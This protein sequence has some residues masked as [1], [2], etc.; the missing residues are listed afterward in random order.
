MGGF[1][2]VTVKPTDTNLTLNDVTTN[3]ASIS[4]HG[5]LPK[6]SGDAK[7]F[8]NGLGAFSQPDIMG[9]PVWQVDCVAG[10]YKVYYKGAYTG[11]TTAYLS[12]AINDEVFNGLDSGRVAEKNRVPVYLRGWASVDDTVAVP[13]WCHFKYDSLTA[14][15][16]LN[17]SIIA[18]LSRATYDAGITIEGGVIDGNRYNQS[19]SSHGIDILQNTEYGDADVTKLLNNT[20]VNC[21]DDSIKV[22]CNYNYSMPF[23]IAGSFCQWCGN[24]GLNIQ[25]IVDSLI[26]DNLL[27]GESY[28]LYAV[29][30][31]NLIHDLYLTGADASLYNAYL[32]GNTWQLN[33]IFLDTANGACMRLHGCVD[34]VFNNLICRKIGDSNDNAKDAI[35]LESNSGTHCTGNNFCNVKVRATGSAQFKYGIEEVDSNQDENIFGIINAPSSV[36][37]TG[38]LRK[39]GASSEHT[40]VVGSVVL[41]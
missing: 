35:Y 29:G 27:G 21:R 25:G 5:F 20:V 38:A 3:N 23:E 9:K 13:A 18:N 19:S 26:H 34:S 37:Q 16:S 33:N 24:A 7:Q 14:E 6:L 22:K 28:N 36:A 4:K 11:V 2:T 15:D 32:Y 41:T 31:N 30:G 10:Y 1:S 39:L 8:M 12:D 17:K 40:A